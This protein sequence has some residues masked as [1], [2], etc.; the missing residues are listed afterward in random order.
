[1]NRAILIVICDFLVS[2]M[3]SMMTGMVP[4]HTGGT[5]VGLDE[6]TT[7]LLLGELEVRQQE[8]QNL[9]RQ[10]REAA[11]RSGRSADSTEEV[12][13]ITREL[14]DNMQRIE[15]VK[16]ARRATAANTGKLSPEELQARLESEARKRLELEIKLRD[17]MLDSRNS[18]EKLSHTQ[19]LLAQERRRLAAAEQKLTSTTQAE[20]A[21]NAE[22]RRLAAEYR[23]VQK[24][25]STSET[26]RRLS[27]RDLAAAR[28][29][30][31]ARDADLAG[32]KN[33]LSEMNK[34]I[35]KVSLERHELQRSL[36]FTT[37]KLNTAERDNA[38][39]KGNL[40]KLERT[41]A[42]LRLELTQAREDRKQMEGLVKR[43]RQ[44]LVEAQKIADE[45]KKA[46]A[47]S[48]LNAKLAKQQLVTTKEMFKLVTAKPA[49][50]AFKRYSGS[51]VRLHYT[52]REKGILLGRAL[53]GDLVP[54]LVRFGNRTLVIA[55]FDILIGA[56]QKSLL[57]RKIEILTYDLASPEGKHNKSVTS[58]MLAIKTPQGDSLGAFEVSMPGRTPLKLITRKQLI[59]RGTDDLF[60]FSCRK[61]GRNSA[62]LVGRCSIDPREKYPYLLI[63]NE[64]SRNPMQLNAELGDIV[65]TRDGGFVG[66]VSGF[67]KGSNEARVL[68]F[69]HVAAWEKAFKIPVVRKRGEKF[70]TGFGEAVRKFSPRKK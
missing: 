17:Q 70:V 58:P 46:A 67:E 68:L 44:E 18:S 5:G 32:V 57:Y 36:A 29:A 33:A 23:S 2:A 37:G 64:K 10:L 19:D 1:M 30:I 39:Y 22:L 6:R 51:A 66:V 27:E 3:L 8:L 28:N 38:E 62:A 53:V 54:V 49:A 61:F 47:Q 26:A 21:A 63:R 34:R 69:S 41:A 7:R 24:Q 9:R 50:E 48:D 20:R 52:I 25:F 14:I 16:R 56:T 45:S 13:K 4:A 15:K 35:G 55:P 31:A 65:V 60:L 43:S 42:Q 59:E 11:L 40:R 12:R